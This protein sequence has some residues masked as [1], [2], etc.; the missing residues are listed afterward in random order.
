MP[1]STLQTQLNFT[2]FT[3]R[4]QPES[5]ATPASFSCQ[6]QQVIVTMALVITANLMM[7]LLPAG[8]QDV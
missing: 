3:S 5:A 6:L 7:M 8:V 1:P 4:D 2:V